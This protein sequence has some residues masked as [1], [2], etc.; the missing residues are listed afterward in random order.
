MI[1]QQTK[2]SLTLN[3]KIAY[4]YMFNLSLT[5]KTDINIYDQRLVLKQAPYNYF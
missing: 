5:Y 2:I 4:S 3:K 1:A